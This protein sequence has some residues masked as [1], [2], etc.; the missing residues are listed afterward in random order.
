VTTG[1]GKET[2][3]EQ[4]PLFDALR[5]Y[6]ARGIYPLHTPGHK[7]GRFADEALISL[8]GSGGLALD[9]PSLEATD[10]TF[11]PTGCIRDSQALAAEL[12]GAEESFFLTAGSTLGVAAAVMSCVPP[13]STVAL[14]RNIHRAVVNGLVLSDARPRF[15]S[16]DVLSECGAL[17]VTV[18]ELEN[19]LD[20]EPRPAAVLLTAPSYYGLSRDLSEHAALCRS[21]GIPLVVDEAHGGHFHFLPAGSPRPAL[22]SGADLV[23]QSWHKTLGSLVGSAMLHVGRGSLVAPQQVRDALNLLQTTSPSYLLLASLDLARRLMARDGERL[24]A[25]AV[26]HARELEDE[27]ERIPRLRVL[28]PGDDPRMEGHLR[29]PLRLVVDVS[30][31]GWTGYEVELHLRN[32][33]R[34]EDEMCDWTNVVYLLSPR[35]DRDAIRR[36]VSGLGSISDN[37]RRPARRYSAEELAQMMQPP[38]PTLSMSPRTAALGPK[39]SVALQESVGRVCAEVVCFYPPGVPL[40]MPGE[41]IT[42]EV[43]DICERLR[44]A[45]AAPHANDPSLSS[46]RVVA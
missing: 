37:P 38:I 15:L 43:V 44:R 35:D 34:V 42:G 20:E 17:G 45:G 46:V 4:A 7:N 30:G 1:T 18:G 33:L 27:I 12:V 23:V 9:L 22:A 32:E 39:R 3:Q 36:L 5:E 14:P 29:D 24:F 10:S 16:H 28:R 13:G 41:I 6:A 40:L 19:A 31:T 21:R 25:R 11:H 26:E 8:V 2:R